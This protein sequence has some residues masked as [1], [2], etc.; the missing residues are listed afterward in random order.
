MIN[1]S[2]QS[3]YRTPKFNGYGKECAYR[4]FSFLKGLSFGSVL[5]VGSGACLLKNWLAENGFAVDYE[6][7]DIRPDALALCGCVTHQTIP[8]NRAYDLVC[9]FGTVTYNID[10]D[11]AANKATLLH[12]LKQSKTVCRSLLLFTVFKE[13]VREK[14]KNSVPADYFVYFSMNEIDAM[15]VTLGISKYTIIENPQLDDQEYF[16]LAHLAA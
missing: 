9:L 16:V 11:E 3:V 14:Y 7:V 1:Y 6:A 13:T 2:I 10:H 5:D 4:R 12:L 8:A 15:M